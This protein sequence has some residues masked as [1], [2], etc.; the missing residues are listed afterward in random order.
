MR[1]RARIITSEPGDVEG[2]GIEIIEG[3]VTEVEVTT[4]E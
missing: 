1:V 3:E 2:E 4:A